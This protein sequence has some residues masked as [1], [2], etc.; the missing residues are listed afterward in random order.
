MEVQ[1]AAP[2]SVGDRGRELRIVGGFVQLT[3]IR[4][5]F[6][7]GSF[8]AGPTAWASGWQKWTLARLFDP[9]AR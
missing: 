5:E 3:T 8:I 9:A 6:P 4:A 1:R 7:A 2:V